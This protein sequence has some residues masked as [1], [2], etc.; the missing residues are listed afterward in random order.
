V[1]LRRL[2]EPD[3]QEKWKG[4]VDKDVNLK[5]SDVTDRSK[6]MEMIRGHWTDS[7]KDNDAVS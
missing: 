2:R 4:V 5:R 3:K 6:W 7:N 1:L